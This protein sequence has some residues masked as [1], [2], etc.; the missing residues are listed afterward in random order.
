MF[1][2]SGPTAGAVALAF[3]RLA[4]KVTKPFKFT[5]FGAIK[6][7]KPY[8]FIGFGPIQFTKP[9]KLIG[10]G[11]SRSPNPL[12]IF[13]RSAQL[14]RSCNTLLCLGLLCLCL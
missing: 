11:P 4:I 13:L 14:L 1:G 8:K 5:G 3:A 10:F 12:G 9:Y 7:T 2:P 6:V